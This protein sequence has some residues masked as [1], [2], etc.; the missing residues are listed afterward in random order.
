[1]TVLTIITEGEKAF[2]DAT[3]D[4]LGEVTKA[5]R[6]A[7][8]MESGGSAVVFEIKL[9]NGRLVYGRTS[10]RMLAAAVLG[11][12]SADEAAGVMKPHKSA[13]H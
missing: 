4:A 1:M 6:L 8:G 5:A 13:T 10:L 3:P 12:T 2:Q 11:F 7:G 9:P